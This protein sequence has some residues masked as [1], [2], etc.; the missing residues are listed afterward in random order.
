MWFRD[1]QGHHSHQRPRGQSRFLLSFRGWA[2][3]Y[4][5][6]RPG[7]HNPEQSHRD[8]D[9]TQSSKGKSA[10]KGQR[11]RTAEPS[12]SG[13]QDIKPKNNSFQALKLMEFALL[14][15]F[16]LT[17]DLLA[18]PL[19]PSYFFPLGMGMSSLHLSQCIEEAHNL[20]GFTGSQLERNFASGWL[21]PEPH[22]YLI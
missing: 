9:I 20:P 4:S 10:T 3:L 15:G 8:L 6:N 13:W 11:D 1:H 14:D 17:W 18:Y 12:W 22:S 19:L 2:H 7:C 16:G 21:I 5:F